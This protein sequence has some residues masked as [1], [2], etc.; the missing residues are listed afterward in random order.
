MSYYRSPIGWLRVRMRARAIAG[1]DCVR[2]RSAKE[3]D[4]LLPR[5]IKKSLDDYFEGKPDRGRARFELEGTPFQ[6]K[7][8]KE[9]RRIPWGCCL[10]YAKL[11]RL[12]GRPKAVRAVAGAVGKNPAAILVPCHRVVGS[13]G[14][15]RGYA[16]GLK[17]KAWLIAHEKRN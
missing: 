2:L 7:V 17:K 10:S 9:L 14:S 12:V 13:D 4:S 15:L 11:A 5:Q 8:W 3:K 6:K 16:Y 1:I